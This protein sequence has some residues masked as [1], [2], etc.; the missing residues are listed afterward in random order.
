MGGMRRASI[1]PVPWKAALSV[2]RRP[3]VVSVTW[4]YSDVWS[5]SIAGI[6]LSC[7]MPRG[8]RHGVDRNSARRR[9]EGLLR[10]RAFLVERYVIGHLRRVGVVPSL[11]RWTTRSCRSNG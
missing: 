1:A 8:A 6:I 4:G 7:L 10:L 11:V 9:R 3:F 2:L 5:P